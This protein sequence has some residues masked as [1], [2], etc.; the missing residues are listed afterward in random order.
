MKKPVKEKSL[1][2]PKYKSEDILP[3]RISLMKPFLKKYGHPILVHAVESKNAFEEIL[4]EGKI[5]L[6]DEHGKQK[7]SPLME[8]FLGIDNSIF[9]SMGFDYWT[10]YGFR[11]NFIFD[12]SILGES[13]YYSRPLPYKCYV[14]IVDYWYEHDRDYLDKLGDYNSECRKVVDKYIETR[15]SPVRKNFFQF[16]KIEDVAFKFILDYPQKNKLFKIARKRMK[17]LKRKY[18]YSKIVA[19]RDWPTNRF[20]EILHLKE[21][22]L[23]GSPYFLGFFIEGNI[24]KSL[25]KILKEK[26]KGKIIFDGRKIIDLIA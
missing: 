8:K 21:I 7:K 9:L 4:R 24:P 3:A 5:S 17:A 14:D 22:D 20:P 2:K 25:E 23:M 1:W 18:P 11:Y 6:P 12:W 15:H 10:N 13:D 16:W 26:Y 19:K